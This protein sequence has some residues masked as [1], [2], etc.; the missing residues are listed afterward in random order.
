MKKKLRIALAICSNGEWNTC[1]SNV[2]NDAQKMDYCIETLPD[3]EKRY[4]VDVEVEIPTDT[5]EII[6][7]E[8]S[9]ASDN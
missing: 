1:G 7:G 8:I 3:G 6:T 5:A 2:F 4:W 9:T